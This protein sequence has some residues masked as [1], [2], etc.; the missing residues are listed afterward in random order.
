MVQVQV[1]AQVQMM[2][3]VQVMAHM[4]PTRRLLQMKT[5]IITAGGVKLAGAWPAWRW[6]ARQRRRPHPAGMGRW[7]WTALG[8]RPFDGRP[9]VDG[10]LAAGEQSERHSILMVG[11]SLPG[12]GNGP[13]SNRISFG[14]LFTPVTRAARVDPSNHGALSETL[15]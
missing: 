13:A 1:M 9:L 12:H 14:F 5:I 8:G 2:L 4:P 10:A 6:R 7:R 15:A 11:E 3:Q